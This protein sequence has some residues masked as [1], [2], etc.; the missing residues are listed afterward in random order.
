MMSGALALPAWGEGPRIDS[1]A[2][3]GSISFGNASIP[4]IITLQAAPRPEGPWSSVHNLFSTHASGQTRVGFGNAASFVRLVDWDLS[5]TPQGF[6]RL[7]AAYGV[8]RTIAGKGEYGSDTYNGWLPEFEGGLATAAELSRPHMAMSDA[9]GNIYIADKDAHAIRK[10]T[11]DGRIHTVAGTNLPGDDGNSAGQA[12]GR[13]LASP[14]GLWVRSDGTFYIL[15]MDNGKI[16]RV[17]KQG[18]MTTL[19]KVSDGIS[20]GRGLWVSDDE[21]L[22]YFASGAL[23]RKWTPSGGVK[24]VTSGFE[25]LGNIVVDPSGALVVTDRGAHRVYRVSPNGGKTIIAGNGKTSGGG[26]GA[27][28]METG[29][30]GVRG[31]CFLPTGGYMLA[32][33]EGSQI[34]YIDTAGVA[35]LFLDGL[36]G[37]HDGDGQYFRSAGPKISEARSV[38]LDAQGRIIIVENDAGFVRVIEFLPA[39]P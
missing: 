37:A 35:H 14:N 28:A 10:V 8:I 16:R 17:D 1:L 6:A 30:A 36:P 22:V 5:A 3:D 38:T 25:E 27:L 26:D 32:T 11:S 9:D 21:S 19:F 15:D 31:I 24:T 23:L 4:G 7:C 34:W 18:L 39:S 29:L 2:R 20:S 33:H 12:T 13:R